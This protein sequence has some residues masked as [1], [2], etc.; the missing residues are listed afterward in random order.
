LYEQQ[1]LSLGDVVQTRIVKEAN[2]HFEANEI[3]D[4][5][6]IR[7]LIALEDA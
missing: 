2:V 4:D 3:P 6:F 5:N 1:K 7:K